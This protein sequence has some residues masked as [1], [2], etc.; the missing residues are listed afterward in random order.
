[1]RQK[2]VKNILIIETIA[3]LRLYLESSDPKCEGFVVKCSSHE[4]HIPQQK[5]VPTYMRALMITPLQ[6]SDYIFLELPSPPV[7]NV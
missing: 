3:R 1:M 2:H 4:V 7:E 5:D 6:E